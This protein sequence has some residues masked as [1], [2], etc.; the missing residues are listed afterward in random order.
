MGAEYVDGNTMIPQNSTVLVHQLAGH[1]IDTIDA[2]YCLLPRLYYHLNFVCYYSFFV[3]GFVRV[4][5]LSQATSIKVM[6][7]V[8]HCKEF[9]FETWWLL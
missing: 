3:G 4:K 8:D 6:Q 1:P 2:S 5:I 7:G 9:T